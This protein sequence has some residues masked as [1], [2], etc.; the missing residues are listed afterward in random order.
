MPFLYL[1]AAR[2][3]P[4]GR[5][6]RRRRSARTTDCSASSMDTTSL[7]NTIR[8]TSPMTSLSAS[9]ASN[10]NGRAAGV[11]KDELIYVSHPRMNVATPAHGVRVCASSQQGLNTQ[12]RLRH[13]QVPLLAAQPRSSG[14]NV[15]HLP[16]AGSFTRLN[17]H[18]D[19]PAVEC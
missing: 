8:N 5:R 17:L 13:L 19:E 14:D 4:G 1:Y 9:S 7:W 18:I 16:L 2:P 10:C 6:F 11:M 3:A 12:G 15:R